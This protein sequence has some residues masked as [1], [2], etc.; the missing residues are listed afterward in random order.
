MSRATGAG[1]PGTEVESGL[2]KRQPCAGCGEETAA[3]SIFF[4]DR[5]TVE[6]PD[7]PPL[8]LCVLCD[9]HLRSRGRRRQLT[10]DEV[11]ILVRSGALLDI[12]WKRF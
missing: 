8:H 6:R 1:R 3:G 10:D 11:R 2:P 12:A 9:A 4:S 7:G 5:R